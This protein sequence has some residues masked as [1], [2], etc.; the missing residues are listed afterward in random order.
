MAE[1]WSQAA[2]T[3]ILTDKGTEYPWI[4]IHTG[5]PG[6]AGTAN[7]GPDTD[8]LQATWAAPALAGDSQSVEMVWTAD[9]EWVA[10][11]AS[12]DP[13]YVSGWS[14]STA[15]VFGWSGQLTSDAIVIGNDFRI[16]AGAYTLRVPIATT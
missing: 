9:L 7:I 13:Q 12:G 8:R 4:Q 2:A 15:G 6:A 3:D 10:V 1:G 5:A 11:A 14:A 16:P